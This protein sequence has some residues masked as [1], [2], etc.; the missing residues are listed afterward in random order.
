MI[1][2]ADIHTYEHSRP[3]IFFE[4]VP[5]NIKSGGN[6]DVY[7]RE[8]IVI[9]Q[10][11]KIPVVGLCGENIL[12]SNTLYSVYPKDSSYDLLFLL[13][14]L[15]STFVQKYWSAKYSDNKA[16]FPKIKGFQLKELPIP[17][18]N[19]DQQQR[20]HVLVEQLL[21]S[22]NTDCDND[23]SELESDIDRVVCSLYG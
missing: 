9:R 12:C 10:I 22:K 1:D 16:L 11:G 20:V 18:A 13:A 6:W 5:T 21:K 8:R 17:I 3:R 14:C 23:T 15:N 2:G 7:A 4:Y 19:K